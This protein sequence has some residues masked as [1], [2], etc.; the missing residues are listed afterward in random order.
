M[1]LLSRTYDRILITVLSRHSDI[2]GVISHLG[3][4]LAGLM[5]QAPTSVA[6]G[7]NKDIPTHS[8]REKGPGRSTFHNEFVQCPRLVVG[9]AKTSVWNEESLPRL[10][11]WNMIDPPDF[12]STHIRNSYCFMEFDH[13]TVRFQ[14]TWIPSPS[15]SVPLALQSSP[16]PSI[17]HLLDLIGSLADAKRSGLRYRIDDA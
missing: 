7:W 6:L 5:R 16:Y 4:P 17:S 13:F 1:S 15:L 14:K 11:R 8:G 3:L 9:N 12:C 2:W 10:R